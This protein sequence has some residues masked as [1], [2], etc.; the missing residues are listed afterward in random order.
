VPTEEDSHDSQSKSREPRSLYCK[1]AD[2]LRIVDGDGVKAEPLSASAL[3][4]AKFK[5]D[6]FTV[7]VTIVVCIRVVPEVAVIAIDATI[8]PHSAGA[9]ARQRVEPMNAGSYLFRFDVVQSTGQDDKG[10]IAKLPCQTQTGGVDIPE[11]ESEA[12]ATSAE[13]LVRFS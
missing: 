2:Y 3:P 6:Y 11:S 10:W 12:Q 1:S 8:R 7:S 13:M 9:V 4:P 5:F